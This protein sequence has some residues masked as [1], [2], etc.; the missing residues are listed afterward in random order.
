LVALDTL[1]SGLLTPSDW[2]WSRRCTG[3]SEPAGV[4]VGAVDLSGVPAR[5]IVELARYYTGAAG[6]VG[7]AGGAVWLINPRDHPAGGLTGGLVQFRPA[8]AR[9]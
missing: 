2:G 5:R 4:G 1:R 7:A 9:R 3:V 6:P 8:L